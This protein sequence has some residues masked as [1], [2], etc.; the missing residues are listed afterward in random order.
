[1]AGVKAGCVHAC[2]MTGNMCDDCDPIWQVTLRIALRW[3]SLPLPLPLPLLTTAGAVDDA[4]VVDEATMRQIK[5]PRCGLSDV[6]VS[7][8]TRRRKRYTLSGTPK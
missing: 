5:I 4:G 8:V 6:T 2:W 3:S 1:M 7:T